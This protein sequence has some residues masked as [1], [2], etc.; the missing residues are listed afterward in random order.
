MYYPTWHV[1]LETS[2]CTVTGNQT[3]KNQDQIPEQK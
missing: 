2:I 1:F 3:P